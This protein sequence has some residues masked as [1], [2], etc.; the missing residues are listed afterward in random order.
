[1]VGHTGNFN[2]TVAAI[3]VLDREIGNIMAEVLKI[4]SALII[5]SDHG[6]AD[7][8]INLTDR[9]AL[10]RNILQILCLF[11]SSG[12]ILNEKNHQEEIEVGKIEVGGILADVAPTILGTYGITPAAGND[13]QKFAENSC[14]KV[15]FMVFYA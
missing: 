7:V 8:K 14:R 11:I 13:R 9:S 5:T 4:N 6:N 10:S 2:A 15:I 3:E 1:M 12:M